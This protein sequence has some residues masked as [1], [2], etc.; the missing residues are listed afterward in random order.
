MEKMT[1]LVAK[2]I[3]PHQFHIFL[4][5]QRYLLTFSFSRDLAQFELGK[6]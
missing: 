6:Y 5:Y 2:R 1:L 3:L 4:S